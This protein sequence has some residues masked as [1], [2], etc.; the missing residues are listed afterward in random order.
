VIVLQTEKE[1]LLATLAE[2]EAQL[3]YVTKE[4]SRWDARRYKTSGHV[5]TSKVYVK[6]LQ[7][8]IKSLKLELAAIGNK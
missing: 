2:K 1:K 7:K 6:N 5:Q 4:A 3:S 8:E